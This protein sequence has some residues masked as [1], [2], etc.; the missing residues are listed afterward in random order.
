MACCSGACDH[1]TATLARRLRELRRYVRLF[2]PRAGLYSKEPSSTGVCSSSTSIR[3]WVA[4]V[5]PKEGERGS[6]TGSR[7]RLREN[8]SGLPQKSAAPA[9][10]ALDPPTDSAVSL[11]QKPKIP[12]DLL[13]NCFMQGWLNHKRLRLYCVVFDRDFYYLQV[14]SARVECGS[15]SREK[16]RLPCFRRASRSLWEKTVHR[17]TSRSCSR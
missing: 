2:G 14:E 17:S 5:R 9:Q 11:Q 4:V 13:K 16:V 10:R 8:P 1:L 12:Q 6:T 3:K 7:M 15:H